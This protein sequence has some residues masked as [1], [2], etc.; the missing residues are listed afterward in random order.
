MRQDRKRE[1]VGQFQN[2][3]VDDSTYVLP[4]ALDLWIV[5]GPSTSMFPSRSATRESL[6]AIGH[7]KFL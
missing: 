2:N 4:I 6:A 1:N 7:R 5:R 3:A